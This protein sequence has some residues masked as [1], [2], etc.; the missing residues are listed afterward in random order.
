M[1]LM[2]I[3]DIS[4]LVYFTFIVVKMHSLFNSFSGPFPGTIT[5]RHW[6]RFLLKE[7]YMVLAG[8]EHGPDQ[9][10]K[11]HKLDVLLWFIKNVD[12]MSAPPYT[13]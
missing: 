7:S 8:F 13:L 2:Y 4:I 3:V 12:T 11:N 10:S 1:C 5:K 9:Q 6:I